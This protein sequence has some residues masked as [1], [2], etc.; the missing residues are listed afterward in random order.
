M[1]SGDFEVL[2]EM[3]T[4]MQT[5]LC[6]QKTEVLVLEMKHYERL[7]V[8]R[9]PRTIENMK[10]GLELRLK[11]RVSKHVEK[12]C[13]IFKTLQ[14]KAEEYNE[15]KKLQSEARMNAHEKPQKHTKTMQEVFDSFVPP[16]G[17]LIDL[18]GP[19]TVFHHIREREKAKRMRQQKRKGFGF[20]GMGPGASGI[21]AGGASSSQSPFNGGFRMHGGASADH[22]TSD[23]VL[24]QLEN[25]MRTWLQNDP[26]H[27][28]PVRVAQLH[29]STTEVI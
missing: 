9:N 3:D 14:I 26:Q 23:P 1:F 17:P 21:A 16:R 6:T 10:E 7:L 11:S 25:R 18:Y 20:N 8:K 24:T 27:R 12:C 19:G 28:G 5:A 13:P 15:Q 29:R 4:Y 22:A 2:L